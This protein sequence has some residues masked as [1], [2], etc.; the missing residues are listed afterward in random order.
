MT[1]EEYNKFCEALQRRGY[2]KHPSPRYSLHREDYAWF[3]SFE[4]GKYEEDRSSYQ[5]CFDVF[6]F[7]EYSDRD[8]F[9]K[10]QRR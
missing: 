4:K 1:R 5:M 8:A 6:D 3:K 10:K 2:K 9:F 7:S